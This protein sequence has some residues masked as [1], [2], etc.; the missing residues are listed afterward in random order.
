MEKPNFSYINSFTGGNKEFEKKVLLIIKNEFPDERATYTAN[1][2][3]NQFAV[4]AN[5]VH[6]IKHKVS[7]LGLEKSYELATKHELNLLEGNNS[8]HDKFEAIMQTMAQFLD[9]L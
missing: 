4:A 3:S 6:K 5:N 7:L 1:I 2:D 8:L 9:D